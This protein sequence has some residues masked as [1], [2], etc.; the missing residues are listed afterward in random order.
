MSTAV[1]ACLVHGSYAISNER[2]FGYN[3]NN[4][5]HLGFNLG[6][7]TW[8]AILDKLGF[9]Y[10]VSKDRSESLALAFAAERDKKGGYTFNARELRL[11]SSLLPLKLV[12]ERLKDYLDANAGP[13]CPLTEK[14]FETR[15]YPLDGRTWGWNLHQNMLEFENLLDRACGEKTSLTHIAWL[16]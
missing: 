14:E 1:F 11:D 9:P 4:P 6:T 7:G 12:R 13:P 15:S 16:S 3:C 2:L 10:P 8:Y 5:D